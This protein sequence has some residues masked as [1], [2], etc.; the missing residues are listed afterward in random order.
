MNDIRR[1][2]SYKPESSVAAAELLVQ[3]N[4]F[5]PAVIVFFAAQSYDGALIARLLRHRFP[6]AQVI[7]CS[8]GGDASLPNGGVTALVLASADVAAAAA[9]LVRFNVEGVDAGVRGAAASLAR[10]LGIDELRDANPTRF[11]G[12]VLFDALNGSAAEASDILDDVAPT[13]SFVAGAADATGPRMSKVFCND[14]ET[15]SGAAL[16]LIDSSVPLAI[17]EHVNRTLTAVWFA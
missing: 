15:T 9:R 11:V 3:L 5:D 13:L 10:E 6:A 4:A 1:I 2:A 12:V 14:T 8:T 7:G 16:L 17:T